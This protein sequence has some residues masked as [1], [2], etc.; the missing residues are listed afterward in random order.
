M[1]EQADSNV[2]DDE[3]GPSIYDE[4]ITTTIIQELGLI[5]EV[6]LVRFVGE[7]MWVTFRD[8]QSALTA[9][10]KKS[11]RIS[12]IDFHFNL[13][14]ENWLAQVEREIAL[15]TTNTV[16]LCTPS[17]TTSAATGDYNSLGIPKKPPSR[18][19]SPPCRPG[20]PTRPPLPTTPKHAPKAGVI[21]VIPAAAAAAQNHPPQTQSPG[22]Q[23]PAPAVPD[24]QPSPTI[25]SRSS[26][27][28]TT[29]PQNEQPQSLPPIQSMNIQPQ[30]TSAIYEEINDDVVSDTVIRSDAKRSLSNIFPFP[31]HSKTAR[32]S[33]TVAAISARLCLRF[34]YK[35]Q[36]KH[37]ESE[38]KLRYPIGTIAAIHVPT[39]DGN[40]AAITASSGSGTSHKKCQRNTKS[41]SPNWSATALASSPKRSMNCM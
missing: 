39:T 21:S 11:I 20:P 4:D 23:R 13:K 31:V 25:S 36:T 17:P 5:G 12:G 1:P 24:Q 33:T 27:S 16:Q 9:V 26:D 10:Q 37:I 30:D 14:T 22:P 34:R 6:T 38:Q 35:H 28:S 2:S 40:A 32:A 41:T 7:T 15:C 19:K 29:S 3:D 18:P 8:G